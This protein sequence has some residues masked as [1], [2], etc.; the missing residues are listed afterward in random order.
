MSQISNVDRKTLAIRVPKKYQFLIKGFVCWL[1][2]HP[3]Q[4]V[5]WTCENA[6]YIKYEDLTMAPTDSRHTKAI[7]ERMREVFY[8]LEKEAIASGS[9]KSRVSRSERSA[10]S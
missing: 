1:K 5:L 4:D 3:N 7:A 6:M 10:R 2:E 8:Y 9:D